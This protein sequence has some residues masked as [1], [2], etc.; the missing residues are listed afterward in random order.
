MSDDEGDSCRTNNS[1]GDGAPGYA[2]NANDN[3]RV[4]RASL[5][6]SIDAFTITRRHLPHWEEPG[7]TYFVTFTL[8]E[9]DICDLAD[10]DL[11]PVI[12]GALRYFAGQRY[13]LYDYTVMPDH[14][15][16][17]IQPTPV[18]G[19][20]EPLWRIMHSLKSWTAQE[21]N[22]RLRRSGPLWLD[23]TYDHMIRNRE[24]YEEKAR[25]IWLNALEKG[26]V[27]HPRH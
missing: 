27:R 2:R 23:E 5:P 24:D 22:R 25:Y 16:A 20:C 12:I 8:K 13:W 3:H 1:E 19:A 26:L 14:V 18:E 7:R 11:A 6:D 21:I 9:P 4:G 17:I 10:S 15:H